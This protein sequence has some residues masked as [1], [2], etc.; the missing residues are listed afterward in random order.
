[1]KLPDVESAAHFDR[2]AFRTPKRIFATLAG[3]GKDANLRLPLEMQYALV[4]AEPEVFARLNGAWGAGGWTRV[5]L[6]KVEISSLSECLRE[7]HAH[8]LVTSSRK[9]TK[10]RSS[11]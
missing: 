7:A 5:E 9:K 1:M 6:A 11:R 8:S 3:T 10:R 4:D 2:T